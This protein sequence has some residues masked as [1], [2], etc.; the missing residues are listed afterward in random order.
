VRVLLDW[1]LELVFPRDIVLTTR[2]LPDSTV[3]AQPAAGGV[4]R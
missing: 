1:L 4:P 2:Q 3:P